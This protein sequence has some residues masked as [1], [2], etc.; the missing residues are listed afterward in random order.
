MKTMKKN[1]KMR[2]MKRRMKRR[3]KTRSTDYTMHVLRDVPWRLE[4]IA[5]FMA[6]AGRKASVWEP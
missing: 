4:D 2:R 6:L 5:N 1:M 3:K